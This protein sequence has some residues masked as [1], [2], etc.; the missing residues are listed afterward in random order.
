MVMLWKAL[1]FQCNAMQY[2]ESKNKIKKYTY[3][4]RATMK[5]KN[6]TFGMRNAYKLLINFM[7]NSLLLSCI[8]S[9]ASLIYSCHHSK[10]NWFKEF[11]RNSPKFF[12]NLFL[13]WNFFAIIVHSMEFCISEIFIHNL[14]FIKKK[15]WHNI[16]L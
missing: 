10:L 6:E 12:F 7:T 8:F 2:D 5:N 3:N 1:P 15:I 4:N 14:I 13:S 11:E 16:S 9:Y